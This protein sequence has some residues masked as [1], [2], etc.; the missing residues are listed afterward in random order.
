MAFLMSDNFP[1]LVDKNL[2]PVFS[3][4]RAFGV[5][6]VALGLA[7]GSGELI[8]WPH[9]VSQFGLG[10]LWGATLGILTEYFINKE[11]ARHALATGES[12]FT[13]SARLFPKLAFFWLLAVLF[14]YVWPGWAGAMGATLTALLGGGNPLVLSWVSL[15]I[16]LLFMLGGRSAYAIMERMVK[17]TVSLFFI[18]LIYVSFLNLDLAIIKEALFGLVNFGWLPEGIEIST[19]VSAIVFAGAGG[20]LNLCV[21]FWYRDKG[22]GM[23]SYVGRIENPITGKPQALSATG[24]TFQP[25]AENLANWKGWMRLVYLDQG[26]FFGLLGV[27]G[28]VLLSLN[29]YATLSP[30]GIAPDGVNII[31]E[32][33]RILGNLWGWAGAKV[34]LAVAYLAL[35]STL[36]VILDVFTRI[37][38]DIFYTNAHAGPLQKF[39]I[40]TKK[41]SVHTIY[42]ALFSLIV[43]IN[44]VLLPFGQPF[45]FLV[46]SAVLSGAVMVVYTPILLY[47]NNFKLPRA[48]RPSLITNLMLIATTVFYAYFSVRVLLSFL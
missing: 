32:Q 3:W 42:Y 31:Q 29:A 9:L 7:I 24:Y 39:F 1:P 28:L 35:F 11:V 46:V 4:R 19:F 15:A 13:S 34:F 6:A 41:Y 18:L 27:V 17:F 44:A 14:L 12:F 30:L 43:V 25:T 38:G 8:F 47:L 37:I 40:W 22:F 2:P 5:G 16:I 26:I 23:G 48:I 33:A 45:V 20:L 10:I 21:S 36:W